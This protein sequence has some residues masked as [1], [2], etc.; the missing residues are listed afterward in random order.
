[1]FFQSDNWQLGQNFFR[2]PTYTSRPPPVEPAPMR[3]NGDVRSKN[4][5]INNASPSGTVFHDTTRAGGQPKAGSSMHNGVFRVWSTNPSFSIT[6]F[7]HTDATKAPI[8]RQTLHLKPSQSP[9]IGRKATESIMVDN[10]DIK[11]P[12]MVIDIH[13]FE[14]KIVIRSLEEDAL[15]NKENN[16]TRFGLELPKITTRESFNITEANDISNSSFPVFDIISDSPTT[17]NV[18]QDEAHLRITSTLTS[19]D[20]DR[21][22]LSHHTVTR[23]KETH[24]QGHSTPKRTRVQQSSSSHMAPVNVSNDYKLSSESNYTADVEMLNSRLEEGSDT[25]SFPRTAQHTDLRTNIPESQDISSAMKS[26]KVESPRAL[27][28]DTNTESD[29]VSQNDQ[30]IEK[31]IKRFSRSRLD[32]NRGKVLHDSFA[33]LPNGSNSIGKTILETNKELHTSRDLSNNKADSSNISNMKFA[34]PES[35]SPLTLPLSHNGQLN[36]KILSLSVKT[37]SAHPNIPR[38]RV[39]GNPNL[40]ATRSCVLQ[41]DG[42]ARWSEPSVKRC[43]RVA[44]SNAHTTSYEVALLTSTPQVVDTLGFTAAVKKLANLVEFAARDEKVS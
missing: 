9:L 16:S 26:T 23:G 6:Q 8:V 42:T 10:K 7:F 20:T 32:G 31:Y 3:T 11:D 40:R 12:K 29:K 5:V 33:D 18:T 25:E 36:N 4:N 35:L 39:S 1:M 22:E 30:P 14:S 43:Q 27:L 38:D 41:S 28:S 34:T 15:R 44:N 13:D 21:L 2:I 24:E 37:H 17:Q 19:Q